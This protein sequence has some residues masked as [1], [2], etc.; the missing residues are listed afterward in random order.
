MLT[1]YEERA[2]GEELVEIER[3]KGIEQGLERWKR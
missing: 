2:S 1:D 3:E